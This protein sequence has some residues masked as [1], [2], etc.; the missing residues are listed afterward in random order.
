MSE[1]IWESESTKSVWLEIE[2]EQLRQARIQTARMRL[3]EIQAKEERDRAERKSQ[4][5]EKYRACM[6]QQ[7]EADRLV[8]A[9]EADPEIPTS[10][11]HV[12]SRTNRLLKGGQA[13]REH[14]AHDLRQ[15]KNVL[16]EI[17]R[18]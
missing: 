17:E 7:A 11:K 18:K 16:R 15:L 4:A 14:A 1:P 10:V 6:A 12:F 3:E 9:V 13:S 2:K 8:M 5:L